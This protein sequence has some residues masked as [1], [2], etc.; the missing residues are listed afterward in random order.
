ML[1]THTTIFFHNLSK[2]DA[3]LLKLIEIRATVRHTSHSRFVHVGRTKMTGYCTKTLVSW[4]AFVFYLVVLKVWLQHSKQR[5]TINFS[6][7]S[8]KNLLAFCKRKGFSRTR[9]WIVLRSSLKI[10]CLNLVISGLIHFLAKSTFLRRMLSMLTK[11]GICLDANLA[12][13]S[14]CIPKLMS[15]FWLSFEMCRRLFDQVY[16]LDPGHYYNAPKI[17]LVT[18]LKQLK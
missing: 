12:T 13:V 17:S 1:R 9:F 2:Y 4:T 5:N 15:F 3:R 14:C 11:F 8:H 6:I 10:R 18:M 7:I 16:G